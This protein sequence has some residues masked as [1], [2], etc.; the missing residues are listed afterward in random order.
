MSEYLSIT[1]YIK[2]NKISIKSKILK[3]EALKSGIS[4]KEHIMPVFKGLDTLCVSLHLFCSL[5]T[6]SVNCIDSKQHQ[7]QYLYIFKAY[8]IE[9]NFTGIVK[10][11]ITSNI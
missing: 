7:L 6:S 10:I 4:K 2:D 8:D 11:G 3:K 5:H 1:K 9:D